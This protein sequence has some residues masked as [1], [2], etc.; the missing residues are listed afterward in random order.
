LGSE[1]GEVPYAFESLFEPF[2][3]KQSEQTKWS[4]FLACSMVI[5]MQDGWNL[6]IIGHERGRNTVTYVNRTVMA[7]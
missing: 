2:S 6:C 5:D 4:S 3:F 7:A 1:F